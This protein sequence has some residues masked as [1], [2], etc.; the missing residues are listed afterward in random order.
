MQIYKSY[1][2]L[3]K[4]RDSDLKVFG[5]E[6]IYTS[7]KLERLNSRLKNGYRY[8]RIDKNTYVES[9]RYDGG[10]EI[11][12]RYNNIHKFNMFNNEKYCISMFIYSM[13]KN[14]YA[15][16]NNIDIVLYDLG[17]TK[18]SVRSDVYLVECLEKSKIYYLEKMDYI[19][20]HK[21]TDQEDKVV[22]I[23]NE[24]FIFPFVFV[25][26]AANVALQ[27]IKFLMKYS[28]DMLK[29]IYKT[30]NNKFKKKGIDVNVESI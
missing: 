5:V 23:L 28:L 11:I 15:Y 8:K 7:H 26:I 13:L 17:L 21:R 22:K 12:K 20:E 10:V 3:L 25:Y 30:Y 4:D 1:E 2:D 18:E 29:Y 24:L 16:K 19:E 6:I 14:D 9:W 27:V